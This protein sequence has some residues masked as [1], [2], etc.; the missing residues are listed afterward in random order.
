[1][2]DTGLTWQQK[3]NIMNHLGD[4]YRSSLRRIDL[5]E[6]SRFHYVSEGISGDYAMKVLMERTLADCSANTRLITQNDFL[7][8][9]DRR[10]YTGYFSQSRYYR[11]RKK[12]VDEF[13][14]CLEI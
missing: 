3:L 14:H 9:K 5:A 10:W 8:V 11:L 7:E 6:D 1:M 12:A 13:L 4:A 2:N